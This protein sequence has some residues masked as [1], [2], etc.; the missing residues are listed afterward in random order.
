MKKPILA[1]AALATLLTLTGTASADCLGGD[2]ALEFQ[3]RPTFLGYRDPGVGIAAKRYFT[4]RTSV[5]AGFTVSTNSTPATF[6]V[7]AYW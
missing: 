4:H 1:V 3:V 7:I 6:S 2:W 5:R